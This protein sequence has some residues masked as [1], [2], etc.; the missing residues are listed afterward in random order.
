VFLRPAV[1]QKSTLF[2]KFRNLRWDVLTASGFLG[3]GF[4]VITRVP[5]FP[6]KNTISFEICLEYQTDYREMEPAVPAL[7]L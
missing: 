7:G 3:V 4:P 1:W 6:A 2:R 5:E